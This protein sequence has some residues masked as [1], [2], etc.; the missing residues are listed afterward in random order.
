MP[1]VFTIQGAAEGAE[2]AGVDGAKCKR[3]KNPKTG[4]TT[5]LCFVGKSKKC[6]SGWRF[7]KGSSSCP[8]RK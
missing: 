5:T 2:G 6:P 1:S 8:K 4:C 3:V 7:M